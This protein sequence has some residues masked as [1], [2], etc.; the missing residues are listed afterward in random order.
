MQ[1]L[2]YRIPVIEWVVHAVVG[3]GCVF[4]GESNKRSMIVDYDA[5]IVL[6]GNCSL[7]NSE[8]INHDCVEQW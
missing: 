1:C 8:V 6:N 5:S 4:S 3:G 7:D 2:C